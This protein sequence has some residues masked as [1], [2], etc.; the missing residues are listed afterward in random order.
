MAGAE[1][2]EQVAVAVAGRAGSAAVDWGQNT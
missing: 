2:W 1:G